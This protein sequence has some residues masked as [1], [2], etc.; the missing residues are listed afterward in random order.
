MWDWL[1][2]EHSDPWLRGAA[3][4]TGFAM[5]TAVVL[6]CYTLGLRFATM[7][8]ARRRRALMDRW[9]GVFALAAL[10]AESART[11][12]LPEIHRH[13]EVDLLVEWNLMQDSVSGEATDN[14][15]VVARRLELDDLARRLLQARGVADRTLGLQTL[16]NMQAVDAWELIGEFLENPNTALSVTAATALVM[17]D[18]DRALPTVLPSIRTRPDW[19]RNQIARLLRAAGAEVLSEHFRRAVVDAVDAGDAAGAARL[20]RY[21]AYADTATVDELAR[22][23]LETEQEPGLLAAA[24]KALSGYGGVPRVA[25]LA[26]HRAWFIRLETAK[27]LGRAG[28]PEHVGLLEHL[29][30]D[31]EWWVRYRA[32]QSLVDLPFLG[33]N[34]LRALRERQHDR[35]ARDMLEELFAERGLA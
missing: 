17:I 19:P 15:V 16:G 2:Q 34:A 29:L 8:H 27:L 25:E 21:S 12:P 23:L 1:F 33:P 14:L 32:A 24:L 20:L 26:G 18:A 22:A 13:E 6:F 5:L 28:A 30:A 10:S 9:R 31:P 7:F 3:L 11:A 35:Y 4:A